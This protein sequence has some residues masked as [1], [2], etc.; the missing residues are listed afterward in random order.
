MSPDGQ[1]CCGNQDEE[2]KNENDAKT[3]NKRPSREKASVMS[4]TAKLLE[5]PSNFA[6][7]DV[8]DPQRSYSR[9]FELKI[10]CFGFEM[11]KIQKGYK[12]NTKNYLPAVTGKWLPVRNDGRLG[13]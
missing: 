1:G 5:I 8:I 13:A 7:D 3:Q 4:S 2:R 6:V 10:L 11:L 12:V 9:S